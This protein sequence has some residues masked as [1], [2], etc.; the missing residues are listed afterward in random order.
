[1]LIGTKGD[2]YYFQCTQ[3]HSIEAR[4]EFCRHH[5]GKKPP[6]RVDGDQLCAKIESIFY[7][8]RENKSEI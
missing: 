1:M 2:L 3:N 6:P 8:H 5:K 4:I 7:V